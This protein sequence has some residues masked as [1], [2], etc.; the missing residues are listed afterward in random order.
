[1]PSRQEERHFTASILMTWK[2]IRSEV[3]L[4]RSICDQPNSS[5]RDSDKPQGLYQ[6]HSDA[7][8][9]LKK[10]VSREMKG[11]KEVIMGWKSSKKGMGS[12]S[13]PGL[14]GRRVL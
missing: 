8:V 10:P 12:V 2:R 4:A 3:Q 9:V 1:M 11:L 5:Q 6:A 14:G 7:H 13:H